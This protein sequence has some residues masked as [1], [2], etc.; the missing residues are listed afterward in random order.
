MDETPSPQTPIEMLLILAAIADENIPAQTIA[1]RFS[2]RF[3]KGVDYVGNVE[4]FAAEFEA[5]L[6]VIDYAV[7]EFGLPPSLKISVH[8]GSDK[9]SI[10]PVI[11]EAI[12]SRDCGLHLK[13]AGTTWLEEMIGLAEAGGDG[14]EIAKEVYAAAFDRYDE[15]CA[16]YADVIDID[17]TAL[18]DTNS[19]NSWSG[20]HF[21]ATLRHDQN[22]P[23][24]NPNLRQL[25]HVGYKVAADMDERYLNALEKHA[26]I[27]AH[28]VKENLLER[29]IKRLWL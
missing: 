29:H 24:Y 21:A 25:L 23:N 11:A 19:V 2:G 18:P 20:A 6:A 8:S 7:K 14:L 26:E 9:F 12:R 3:N 1:P 13:T 17:I 16:P 5:D 22:C 10:Y 4:I 15:L 27:I 28:N